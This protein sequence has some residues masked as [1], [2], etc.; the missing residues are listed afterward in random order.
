MRYGK[1]TQHCL[2]SGHERFSVLPTTSFKTGSQ[3]LRKG[4]SMAHPS[5]GADLLHC[6]F[7]SLVNNLLMCAS[8]SHL[9]TQTGN[10]SL[11]K[12]TDMLKE[13]FVCMTACCIQWNIFCQWELPLMV[14]TIFWAQIRSCLWKK[15]YFWAILGCSVL[16]VLSLPCSIIVF[17]LL[18]FL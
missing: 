18:C 6:C 13:G 11:R 10:I 16:R 9:Y 15:H 7:Q 17:I 3:F 14:S 4:A 2:T 5:R 12:D 1:E 8:V